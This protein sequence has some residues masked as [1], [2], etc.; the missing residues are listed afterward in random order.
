[1]RIK[2][3]IAI[4]LLLFL[5]GRVFAAASVTTNLVSPSQPFNES[6]E[7]TI[8]VILNVNTTDGTNYYLGGVFRK[9][10]G[11]YC[12]QTL[13]DGNWIKY[14]NDGNKFFKISMQNDKWEG[15]VR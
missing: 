15:E 14:G 11:N 4:V 8:H 9:D 12:G 3:F 5:P 6:T 13:N 10:S 1:M 2:A 7:I